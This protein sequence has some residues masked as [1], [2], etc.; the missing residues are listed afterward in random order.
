MCLM[1]HLLRAKCH[2]VQ[3]PA[4]LHTLLTLTGQSFGLLELLI[5]MTSGLLACISFSVFHG[6]ACTVRDYCACS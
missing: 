5:L 2:S 4:L 1:L 3:D 6:C